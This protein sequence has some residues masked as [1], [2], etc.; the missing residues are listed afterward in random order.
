MI[1]DFPIKERDTSISTMSLPFA[2][3][4]LVDIAVV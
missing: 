4:N 1:K 2:S 3:R